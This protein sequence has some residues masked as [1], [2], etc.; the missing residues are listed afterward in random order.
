MKRDEVRRAAREERTPRTLFESDFLLR[1]DDEVRMGALRFSTRR[2]GP[3]LAEPRQ[4]RIPP[5]V[6]LRELLAASTR[7]TREEEG[8]D[9]LRLLLGP[10][11]SLGGARPKATVRDADGALAIAKFPHDA[12]DY[13]IVSWEGVALSLAGRAG[14]EVPRWRLEEVDERRVLILRRFDREGTLRVP[15]L[16]AMSMLDANDHE[17]RSYLEIADALRRHGAAAKLGLAELW[18]RI[19]FNILISNTDDHLRNHGF[20]YDH[21]HGWHLSPAY[22]LNPTPTQIGPRVLRT[23]IDEYDGTASL[24]GALATAAYYGLDLDQAKRIAGEV[25]AAVQTWRAEAAG[26]GATATSIGR[27]ESAFEHDDLTLARSW[28]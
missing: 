22:D 12:D 24:D 14:I 3:F 11:A 26:L 21:P 28:I 23:Y 16:S 8:D 9:D 25:A 27:M 1:V 2:D 20:L 15:F 17:E 5:L 13:D 7:V 18:R 10:G 6:D 19:V 4:N